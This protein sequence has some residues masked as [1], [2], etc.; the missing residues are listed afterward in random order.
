MPS[1]TIHLAAA[2]A[3][4]DKH[5]EENRAEFLEGAIAPD[6][7]SETK[8][9]HHSSPNT[10]ESALAFLKGKINI[11]DCLSDFDTK[12]SYGRGY[13]LHLITDD[14]F[15]RSLIDDEAKLA[16]M[17]YYDYKQMLY[18]DYGTMNEFLKKAYGIV[19]PE[20]AKRFDLSN[21]DKPVL[22]SRERIV[23]MIEWLSNLDI[24]EHLRNL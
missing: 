2:N 24:D 8:L 7:I 12:T 13:A 11:K 6:F 22:L 16:A 1:I 20:I 4:L 3:Y 9:M 19:F 14:E 18:H 21:D 23:E 17:S 15:Y 5:P 10:H